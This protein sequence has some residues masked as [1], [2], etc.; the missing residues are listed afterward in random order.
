MGIYGTALAYVYMYGYMYIVPH[1]GLSSRSS[2]YG[3]DDDDADD[4]DDVW[5][6]RHLGGAAA[7]GSINALTHRY[8]THRHYTYKYTVAYTHMAVNIFTYTHA[9]ALMSGA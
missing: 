6:C 4:D 5:L 3:D 9:L 7:P 8:P 2:S 1:D